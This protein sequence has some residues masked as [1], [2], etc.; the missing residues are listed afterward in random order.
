MD[1]EKISVIVIDSDPTSLDVT[2]KFFEM[3]PMV[4]E[5]M[6]AEDSD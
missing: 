6:T 3:N 2:M 4:E 5:V 1:F